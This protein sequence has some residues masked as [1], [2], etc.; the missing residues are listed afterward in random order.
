MAHSR[1]NALTLIAGLSIVAVLLLTCQARATEESQSL[2]QVQA[3]AESWALAQLQNGEFTELQVEAT[4]L[5]NRLHLRAC[6]HALETFGS[7]GTVRAGRVTVGV[8][9]SSPVAWTLY[10]PVQVHASVAVLTTASS[11]P[12]GAVLDKRDLVL[13]NRGVQE[14]PLNYVSDPARAIDM[15]LTHAVPANTL[16][17]QSML[18]EP[19]LVNKGQVVTITAEGSSYAVKMLGTA[20]QNG[21][22]G[23]RI[24]VR[25][26]TSGRTVEAVVVDA[27]TVKVGM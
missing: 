9:C 15:A 18:E 4:A 11:L 16:L 19:Q 8:R 6:D 17:T 26:S 14:L 23:Q 1:V 22:A 25:N 21:A 13:V 20:L 2:Q 3:T 5:D 27:S 12:K 24:G 7:V 10:V